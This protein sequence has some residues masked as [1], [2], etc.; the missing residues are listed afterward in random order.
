M[1]SHEHPRSI[2]WNDCSTSEQK[3][4]LIRPINNKL[5]DIYTNVKNI[6]TQVYNEGDHALFK[7]NFDFDNVQTKQLQIPYE[8]IMH[9]GRNLSNGIKQAIHTA[10]ANITQFHQAHCYSDVH[11]ETFPGVHCQQI[12]RPLN[13]VGLYIPGGTAPLLS[14]VMMLGIP[15]H[16]AKCRRVILCSPPPIPD[17]IIYTAQLCGIDEIYQVGGSQ[18]I[19]AMGFGTESIPKVNKIFGPGNIWVTEAKRQ[20][21]LSPNG[22]AIDMLAGPSEILIIAD[23]T[24]NPIFIAA[25]LLSQAEHG[26]DSHVILITP[27]AYIVEQTKHELHKQLKILPRSNIINNVLLNSR[28]I[29]TSNLMECFSIS[30]SYA[31]EHLSI[32]IENASDYLHHITNAGSIFLGHWSPGTAGDYAS[33]P[34]HVLPTYGHA[35]TTSGLGVIDFQKRMSVQQLTQHGLLQLSSTITTL[36]KIEQLKAHEYAVT[37][38]IN[39]I[40]EQNERSLLG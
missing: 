34:N 35:I 15:A 27:H 17:I 25:D 38:R 33:G 10:M 3:T 22:T 20:I 32:Q 16:I 30:N 18:A 2:Y 37:H 9:S 29:I 31:P 21:N 11:L 14:T 26:P 19:A 39:Y 8:I 7:F 13:I 12:I 6:L 23:H 4:L 1:N 28:M 36:T 40:K 5:N 24:A